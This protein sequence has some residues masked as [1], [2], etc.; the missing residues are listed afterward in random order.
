MGHVKLRKVLVFGCNAFALEVINQLSGQ[1]CDLV[2]VSSDGVCLERAAEKGC[3]VIETDYTDD[4]VLRELGIGSDVDVVFAVFDDDAKNVFLTISAKY[5]APELLII[6]KSQSQD[7]SHKL[8][9]AGANKVI[10]PYEIAGRKILDIIKR[11][12][13]AE[14]IEKVVFGQKD[15]R[16]AELEVPAGSPL[17]GSK[18]GEFGLAKQHNLIL[19]GIVDRELGDE[20]IFVTGGTEHQ[21]DAGDMLVVI[22]PAGEIEGFRQAI[23]RPR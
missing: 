1:D 18:L 3:R 8:R 22:G 2:M 7:S 21:L 17:D 19:L 11:P 5:L 6:A 13:I 4:E 16:L 14:T 9:A 15:L 23:C 10:E 20:F 12:L